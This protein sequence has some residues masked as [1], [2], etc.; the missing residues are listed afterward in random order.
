[1][2]LNSII[3]PASIGGVITSNIS[4]TSWVSP[5]SGTSHVEYHIHGKM[6]TANLTFSDVEIQNR[7]ITPEE[8]K[9]RLMEKLLEKMYQESHI[10]FTK[11]MDAST[12]EHKFH[13]R[14]FA[15]PDT[16]VRIIREQK[17]ATTNPW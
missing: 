5:N 13:A 2:A 6:Y 9:N 15:V 4:N 11:M 12:G 3:D 10:E 1:M 7:I 16:Q 8:I 17:L 14:I